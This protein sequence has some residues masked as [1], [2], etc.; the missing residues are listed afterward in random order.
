MWGGSC[1]EARDAQRQ[2]T[3]RIIATQVRLATNTRLLHFD[4]I[5]MMGA[6]AGS[7]YRKLGFESSGNSSRKVASAEGRNH[8]DYGSDLAAAGLRRTYKTKIPPRKRF[9]SNQVRP[10]A[11][12]P[13]RVTR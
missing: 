12:E 3:L 10:E 4:L 11:N 1:C 6:L 5:F 2:K 8:P 7:S 13:V 9:T